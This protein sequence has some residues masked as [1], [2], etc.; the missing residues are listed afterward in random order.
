VVPAE[1]DFED[2]SA[3]GT[4]DLVPG[5][6]VPIGGKTSVAPGT[7][8]TVHLEGANESFDLA[9]STTVAEDG[10]YETTANLSE[11]DSGTDYTVSVTADGDRLSPVRSGEFV[12]TGG[13]PAAAGGGGGYGK[14]ADAGGSEDAE[15]V[16]SQ[17]T[18]E[19]PEES[20]AT[21]LPGVPKEALERAW[22][23][24]PQPLRIGLPALL[25]MGL[26]GLAVVYI[27][28]GVRRLLWP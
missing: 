2:V 28:G 19:R 24:V 11:Y 8:V 21:P 5:A 16:V 18:T 17:E 20:A 1:A 7:T 14:R 12:E 3:N 4:L 13:S 27:L 26:A 10:T 9:R 25:V 22:S 23:A 6:A 15:A